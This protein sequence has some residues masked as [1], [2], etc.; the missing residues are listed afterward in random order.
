MLCLSG[1]YEPTA[2]TLLVRVG[3]G[4][5]GG[6]GGR[7]KRTIDGKLPYIYTACTHKST[8]ENTIHVINVGLLLGQ[9]RKRWTN[10]QNSFDSTSCA[11]M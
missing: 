7:V 8:P 11:R 10:F 4:E 5:G 2:W 9:R 1:L 3:G 6:G